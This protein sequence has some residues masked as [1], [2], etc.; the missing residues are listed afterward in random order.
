MRKTSRAMARKSSWAQRGEPARPRGMLAEKNLL[1]KKTNPGNQF[2]GAFIKVR[3]GGS[4]QR[5]RPALGR[6]FSG[7][8]MGEQAAPSKGNH[9][10][11][12][13][14]NRRDQNSP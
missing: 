1:K 12:M 2:Y 8:R 5:T 4:Q 14:C 10:P 11:V 13:V 9:H 3:V 6:R 7:E